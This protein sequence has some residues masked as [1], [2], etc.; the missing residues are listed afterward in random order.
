[1]KKSNNNNSKKA[2][3]KKKAASSVTNATAMKT[4]VKL[5]GCS[6]EYGRSLVN[7]FTGPVAC[8]PTYPVSKTRKVRTFARGTFQTSATNGFGYIVADPSRALTND[9]PCVVG[10]NSASTQTSMDWTV[11]GQNVQ[12]LSNSEYGFASIGDSP[13][14]IEYKQVSA[15]LKVRYIGTELDR[16]GQII[17]LQD[18][19]HASVFQRN[20]SSVDGEET[21]RRFAI[22]RKWKRVLFR[23]LEGSDLD[24]LDAL[25]TYTPGPTDMSFFMCFV[26]QAPNV[27]TSLSFEFEFF[28][29]F[30]VIGRNVRGL[31]TSH[32]D[33]VGA[34][35]VQAVVA[36]GENLYPTDANSGELEARVVK[37]MADYV[38]R[39]T[40]TF[41]QI[42][43]G[44]ASK[45]PSN[46]GNVQLAPSEG[47]DV[48]DDI[49]DLV[50]KGT[51]WLLHWLF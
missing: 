43:A 7:P 24:F 1:M 15:G 27:T 23:P 4:L 22:D 37:Q 5:G 16:G 26:I 10:S 6:V 12:F 8:V 44:E 46:N 29:N 40:T 11:V 47:G 20:I 14:Q 38:H 2:Q 42:T 51:N 50:G 25:S 41:H 35:A 33:P 30:E 48:V 9:A 32:V 34:A 31:T 21:S 39:N 13:T 17:G 36:V 19:N 45:L 28:A 49:S 3:K 18:Q